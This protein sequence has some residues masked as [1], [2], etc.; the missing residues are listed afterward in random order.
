MLLSKEIWYIALRLIVLWRS[1]MERQLLSYCFNDGHSHFFLFLRMHSWTFYIP[2][3]GGWAADI[4]YF[5]EV[6]KKKLSHSIQRD[7]MGMPANAIMIVYHQC[8]LQYIACCRCFKHCRFFVVVVLADL[9]CML[10]CCG[11]AI[12]T[13]YSIDSLIAW[14][15]TVQGFNYNPVLFIS[16]RPFVWLTFLQ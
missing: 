15:W 4:S 3:T 6:K 5:S 10:H 2:F 8:S 7:K 16:T 1:T 12:I 13:V 9:P 14:A 11:N